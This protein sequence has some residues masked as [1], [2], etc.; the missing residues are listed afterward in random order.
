MNVPVMVRLRK[1]KPQGVVLYRGPSL[2]N[3]RRI[4]VV[5]TGLCRMSKNPKTGNMVQNLHPSGPNRAP[6][7][8]SRPVETKP[9]AVTARTE[10]LTASW[11]RATS[12]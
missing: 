4:V 7:Q 10:G 12:T 6:Y 9:S 2:L 5:A 8:P 11:V 1:R 3:G